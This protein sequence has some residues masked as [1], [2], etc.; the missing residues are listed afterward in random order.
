[1][2]EIRSFLTSDCNMQMRLLHTFNVFKFKG[3]YKK[4][5]R[6]LGWWVGLGSHTE[7]SLVY[8]HKVGAVKAGV[9]KGDFNFS[10]DL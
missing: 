4:K 1:M 5:S 9:L 6:G 10:D 8:K 2:T 7:K 3:F